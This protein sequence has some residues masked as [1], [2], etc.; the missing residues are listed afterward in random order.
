MGYS[1]LKNASLMLSD[2]EDLEQAKK[3]ASRFLTPHETNYIEI[4]DSDKQTISIGYF[5][6]KRFHWTEDRIGIESAKTLS[7]VTK[8]LVWKKNEGQEKDS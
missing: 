3:E 5:D 4:Q 1:I 2:I 6:G 7:F 8:P